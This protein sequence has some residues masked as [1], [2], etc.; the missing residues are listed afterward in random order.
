M[1]ETDLLS[2]IGV[3]PP[4]PKEKPRHRPGRVILPC[5]LADLAAEH[6]TALMERPVKVTRVVAVSPR[7]ERTELPPGTR[8]V[9]YYD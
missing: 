2:G 6:L 1:P 4:P 5:D 7:E 9:A 8:L 3:A